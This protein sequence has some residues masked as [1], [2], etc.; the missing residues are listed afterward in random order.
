MNT[1]I[2]DAY[3]LGWKL[4]SVVDGARIGL[5]D[6]YGAE[7]IPVARTVLEMSSDKMTRTLEQ[8]GRGS[9]DGLGSAL[10]GMVDESMTTGLGIRYRTSPMVYR[11]GNE[12]ESGPMPGDRAR[13]P[14]A[15]RARGSAATSSTSR[16]DRSGR[17]SP[18]STPIRSSST[19]PSR[20]TCTCA[21]SDRPRT[22]PSWTPRA[23]SGA[24]TR[25]IP[26]SSSSSGPTGTSS[27]GSRP[28]RRRT[29]STT[30]PRSGRTATRSGPTRT[31]AHGSSAVRKGQ[32]GPHARQQHQQ[33]QHRT[34]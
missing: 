17:C 34:A 24:S 30:W 11:S 12:P 5:L 25:L 31:A 18:T 8:V 1:G 22:A 16:G 23:S 3:N 7:R 13:T 14:A 29:S 15:W 9:E 20:P 33:Y 19:T 21:G 27:P 4:T 2:Q 6:T 28:A 32:K 10:A 26:A